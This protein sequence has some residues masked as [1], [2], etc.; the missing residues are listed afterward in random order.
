MQNGASWAHPSPP[1]PRWAGGAPGGAEACRAGRS[2]TRGAPAQLGPLEGRAC[3]PR[4]GPFNTSG[5]WGSA[6]SA[7]RGPGQGSWGAD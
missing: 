6:D 7:R 3:L 4:A 2:L 5:L 1:A